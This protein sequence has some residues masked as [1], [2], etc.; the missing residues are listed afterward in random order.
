MPVPWARPGSGFTLLMDAL[1]L[2]LAQQLPVAQ[3]FGVSENPLWRAIGVHVDEVR[4]TT[5]YADVVALGVD[6]KQVGRTLGYVTLFQDPLNPRVIG[7]VE[8][9]KAETFATFKQDFVAHQGQPDAI[10][11]IAM[12]MSQALQAGARQHFPQA[13]ICFDAFYLAKLVHDAQDEV[14]R[15]EAKQGASLKGARWGLPQVA[16][17]LDAPT[18][19]RHA[20]AAA[21]WLETARAW[22]MKQRFW[23]IHHLCRLGAAPNRST[24][25]GSPGLDA[26]DWNHSSDWARL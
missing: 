23:E 24:G 13:E 5:T 4:A 9:R 26:R 19:Q 14:R 20:L 16:Q 21:L 15:D 25:P 22:R 1:V 12:D 7:L 10:G 8:G 17:G 2:A 18:D 3:M 6:E 11:C